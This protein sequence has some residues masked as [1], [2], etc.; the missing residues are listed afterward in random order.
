MRGSLLIRLILLLLL[1][2]CNSEISSVSPANG[3]PNIGDG[4]FLS[5]E[6]CGAPCL[7][8]IIPGITNEAQVKHILQA[9]GVFQA[10]DTVNNEAESGSRG[11]VCP[12]M[13][14]NFQRGSDIVDGVG[15]SPSQKF[16]FGQAIEKY[17]APNAVLLMVSGRPE[18]QPRTA[19]R[20]YYDDIKTALDLPEQEGVEFDVDPS[21]QIQAVNYSSEQSYKSFGLPLLKWKG[22]GKYEP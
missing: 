17:G 5:G 7:W 12:L 16:T 2:A 14:V 6:P 13:G 19:M 21:V 3:I 22:F 20:L 8:D 15:F 1:S 11:I 9:K 4:G 10:C 18:E